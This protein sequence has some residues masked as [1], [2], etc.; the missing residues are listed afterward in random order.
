MACAT[1]SLPVPVSPS[2]RTV[3][4]VGATVR[5]RSNT[6]RR[7]VLE[8]TMPS[9][10]VYSSSEMYDPT[11]GVAMVRGHSQTCEERYAKFPSC[12]IETTALLERILFHLQLNQLPSSFSIS[13]PFSTTLDGSFS[14]RLDRNGR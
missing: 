9:R 12:A 4:S 2:I 10:S 6:P 14:R 5:I 11:H 1:S 3:A 13:A 8:P 7:P